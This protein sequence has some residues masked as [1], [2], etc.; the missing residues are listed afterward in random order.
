MA[1]PVPVPVPAPLQASRRSYSVAAPVLNDA[2][3]PAT[4][5]ATTADAAATPSTATETTAATQSTATTAAAVDSHADHHRRRHHVT[6]TP[7]AADI[8]AIKAAP[9]VADSQEST[10]RFDSLPLSPKTLQS[11]AV[12]FKYQNMSAVQEKVLELLPYD[13]DLLVRAKTGTG[14]TLAFLV[15]AIESVIFTHKTRPAGVPIVILSPTRELALQIAREAERLVRFHRWIVRTAVGGQSRMRNVRDLSHG[16]RCDIIVATPGRLN[17]LLRSEPAVKA[18][19][20]GCKVLIFDEAD[21][22]LD[23]GFKDELQQIT[24]NLPTQRQTFMFSATLSSEIRS[25]AASTLERGYTAID[26]VPKNETDTHLRIKQTYAV[27]PHSQQFAILHDAIER[28]RAASTQAKIIV[29]FPTTK[30][31]TFAAEVFNRIPGCEV[32][33]MHSKLTQMQRMK[34]ADR[35]RRASSAVLFTSDVSA[36]GVDYPGVSLVIQFGL[37]P[38]RDGYIHRVGRTGRA[39]KSGEGLIILSPYEKRFLDEMK[40]VPIRK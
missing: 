16:S 35:F 8:E 15:A 19:L 32:L 3:A 22:L 36:R 25:I 30:L 17:D 14:K 34:I 31:T 27:V 2:V 7:T 33:E 5:S 1:V 12:E 24:E 29:F 18:Q 28:Q 9:A 38:S 6:H 40:D 4:P 20:A 10:K 11:L 21:V 23:M 39:G 37:P 26:T 13:K